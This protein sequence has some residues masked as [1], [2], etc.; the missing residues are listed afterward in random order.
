MGRHGPEGKRAAPARPVPGIAEL[1]PSRDDY[2]RRYDAA[3]DAAIQAGHVLDED[4]EA[5]L[6]YAKPEL[7]GG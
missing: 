6:A 4:R 5:L 2:L 1:H 7:V 3:A